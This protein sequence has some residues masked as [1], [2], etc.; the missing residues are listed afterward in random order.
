MSEINENEINGVREGDPSVLPEENDSNPEDEA[1]GEAQDKPL[2]DLPE[3][4]SEEEEDDVENEENYSNFQPNFNQQPILQPSTILPQVISQPLIQNSQLPTVQPII[5]QQVIQQQ[6]LIQTIN[7]MP[8]IIQAQQLAPTQVFQPTIIQNGLNNTNGYS[9]IENLPNTS[10]Y[11]QVSYQ[12]A[13]NSSIIPKQTLQTIQQTAHPIIQQIIPQNAGLNNIVQQNSLNGVNLQKPAILSPIVVK[14]IHNEDNSTGSS[15]CSSNT[16][17]DNNNNNNLIPN[18]IFRSNVPNTQPIY[19]QTQPQQNSINFQKQIPYQILTPI[20]NDKIQTVVLSNGN[21]QFLNQNTN[22]TPFV[23][24]N[25]VNQTLFNGQI[26][27]PQNSVNQ[28]TAYPAQQVFTQPQQQPQKAPSTPN[29]NKITVTQLSSDKELVSTETINT[30]YVIRDTKTNLITPITY[31]TPKPSANENN[32][33]IQIINSGQIFNQGQII[34]SN[35]IIT[36]SNN[37]SNFSNCSTVGTVGFVPP[38]PVKTLNASVFNQNINRIIPKIKRVKKNK[39]KAVKITGKVTT[40]KPLLDLPTLEPS[41]MKPH[42]TIGHRVKTGKYKCPYCSYEAVRS[43]ELQRHLRNKKKCGENR[44]DP[45][46]KH[47]CDVPGCDA[48]FFRKDHLDT[49][50]RKH[51]GEKPYVCHYKNQNGTECGKLFARVDDR[52]R[53][54]E[55]VHLQKNHEKMDDAWIEN[56]PLE[57]ELE[58]IRI[59]NELKIARK[60]KMKENGGLSAGLNDQQKIFLLGQEIL[61]KGVQKGVEKYVK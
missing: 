55:K 18:S 59:E 21:H 47:I 25:G 20:E 53:H 26:I 24:Q 38:K 60:R 37:N 56:H 44:P 54:H 43:D 23:T 27:T 3:V 11:Q 29:N 8:Q 32:N 30:T 7:S 28:T 57:K 10:N 17:Q 36:N 58:K 16:S 1:N 31:I 52:K 2:F 12:Y 49:H 22:T 41:N 4:S 13:T 14:P 34:N 35:Q 19:I 51:T 39:E 33:N 61:N 5:Q 46:P 9:T 45:L 15:N 48:K 50:K 40:S 6:P 42:A